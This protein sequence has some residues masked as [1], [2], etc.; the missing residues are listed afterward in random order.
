ME[1][2]FSCSVL[3]HCDSLDKRTLI[4][5]GTQAAWVLE[6]EMLVHTVNKDVNILIT[7]WGDVKFSIDV[8]DGQRMNDCLTDL[9]SVHGLGQC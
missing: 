6:T 7:A 3:S 9:I 8:V 4:V 5:L 1:S 2:I